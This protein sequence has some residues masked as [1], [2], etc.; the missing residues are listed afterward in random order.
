MAKGLH[1]LV[2]EVLEQDLCTGCGMCVALCSNI[3]A[4]RERVAVIRD[5]RLVEGLCYTVCPRTET[6]VAPLEKQIFGGK[7]RDPILGHYSKIAM[8]QATNNTVRKVGQ[9]GG[10]ITALAMLALELGIADGVLLVQ[11]VEDGQY[12]ARN[13]LAR[14]VKEVQAC[15]GSKYTACPSLKQLSPVK[16][17]GLKRIAV[18]GRPCQVIALRKL[19][20]ANLEG[21]VA[22][23]IRE[24]VKLVIGLFC[25]WALEY[26]SFMDYLQQNLNT[27]NF[28]R[29]DIP[30]DAVVIERGTERIE[31]PYEELKACRLRTC[32]ICE[33]MTAELADISVG[34]TEWKDDWN[35]LIVRTEK[36]RELV[37]AALASGVIT[38]QDLPDE[39]MKILKQ[40][41]KGKKERARAELCTVRGHPR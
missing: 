2:T 23:E 34:S 41:A 24:S 7:E 31:V 4:V 33:D 14:S 35:T 3:I 6:D 26:R 13:V 32:D 12:A 18:V 28:T 10:T 5:C 17:S 22:P 15:A 37:E 27:R 21:T 39:R 29:I 36:G 30:K 9:Y 20:F 25:V 8:S 1:E 40:A 11:K 38:L 16:Q 19:Q